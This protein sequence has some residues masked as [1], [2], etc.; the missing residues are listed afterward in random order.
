[1]GDLVI[2]HFFTHY[3]R[4]RYP[5]YRNNSRCKH[6]CRRARKYGELAAS[7]PRIFAL[8]P[9]RVLAPDISSAT[10]PRLKLIPF[11][12]GGRQEFLQDICC[13]AF[14]RKHGNKSVNFSD[15]VPDAQ[16]FIRRQREPPSSDSL[17][18]NLPSYVKCVD[19]N[20]KH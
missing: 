15:S 13:G 9:F 10:F 4:G 2:L 20:D 17:F 12:E 6:S 19:V 11:F 5:R 3:Y 7:L 18:L 1:M 14:L 8:V 16:P